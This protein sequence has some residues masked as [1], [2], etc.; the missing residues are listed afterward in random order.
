MCLRVRAPRLGSRSSVRRAVT[1]TAGR[2]PASGPRPVHCCGVA[3]LWMDTRAV[4]QECDSQEVTHALSREN[5]H[6]QGEAGGTLCRKPWAPVK[7]NLFVLTE[8][9]VIT[10]KAMPARLSPHPGLVPCSAVLPSTALPCSLTLSSAHNIQTLVSYLKAAFSPCHSTPTSQ[11]APQ[12]DHRPHTGRTKAC[13][14]DQG[15]TF[16]APPGLPLLALLAGSFL[17]THLC[18]GALCRLLPAGTLCRQL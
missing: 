2:G 18:A 11:M 7:W 1:D 16:W 10:E 9:H 15:L 12:A 4:Q 17:K 6:P 14:Q 5:V 8:R 13:Q 3:R